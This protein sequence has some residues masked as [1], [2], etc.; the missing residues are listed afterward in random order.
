M[1]V[2]RAEL[3]S[4]FCALSGPA[5][6]MLRKTHR[7]SLPTSHIPFLHLWDNGA[8]QEDHSSLPALRFLDLPFMQSSGK[9]RQSRIAVGAAVLG[10]AHFFPY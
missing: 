8:S 7:A 10:F 6:K 2:G 9:S 5:L 1:D 4:L 3:A